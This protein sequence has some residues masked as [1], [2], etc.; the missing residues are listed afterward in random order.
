MYTLRAI[1]IIYF[2]YKFVKNDYIRHNMTNLHR[3]HLGDET[4]ESIVILT[5]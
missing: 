2:I 3:T 4:D 5:K 1:N